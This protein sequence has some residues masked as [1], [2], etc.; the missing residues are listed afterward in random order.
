MTFFPYFLFYSIRELTKKQRYI[1][2][3]LVY[4][5]NSLEVEKFLFDYFD[6]IEYKIEAIRK[7]IYFY[8][9]H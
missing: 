5:S 8:L 1:I 7:K 4:Y 9:T 2:S 3:L 6:Q